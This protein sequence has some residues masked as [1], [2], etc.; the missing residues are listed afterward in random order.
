MSGFEAIR[1]KV[2]I[3]GLT[4]G[5]GSGKSSVARLF[6]RRFPISCLDADSVVHKLLE[7]GQACWEIIKKID[8]FFILPDGQI[9]KVKLRSALFEND[10]FRKK[11]NNEMHPVVQ[12][13]IL[14]KI[15]YLWLNQEQIFFL[16][17]VPLLFE[18]KWE[19]IFS[20][21]I[22][23]FAVEDICLQRIMSRDRVAKADARRSVVSQMH[24]IEKALRANHVIENS[25]NWADTILQVVHLGRL[26]W[27]KGNSDLKKS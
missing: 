24:S 20:E 22:S 10:E 26:L 25:G 3:T 19:N 7:P 6:A 17:E 2:K 5:I 27:L 18:A 14:E 8:V 13:A 23:V 1:E 16:I 21:V 9:D 11:I 12:R 4:G 15:Y